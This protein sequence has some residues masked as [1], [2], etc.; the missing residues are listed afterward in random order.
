[1]SLGGHHTALSHRLSGRDNNL[2]L[3]RLIAAMAVLISHAFPIAVGA[4][5][6]E[7]FEVQTGLSLG[8]H[9]VAVFFVLSGL[10]I[11][12]S[13]DR[14]GSR[15]R[16]VTA[17]VMRLFPG[18]AVVLVLTVLAGAAV[19]TLDVTAYL[20]DP[21]TILYVPRNLSLY[22]LQY[23]LP[24]VFED[25][26]MGAAINGSLW[27]LF[28]EVVCYI[29]VF[30]LGVLGVLRRRG[31][32]TVVFA[33]LSAAFLV[34]LEWEPA[35]GLAYRLDLLAH[36]AFPFALGILAYVWRDRLLIDFRI[37]ALLWLLPILAM[38][39]DLLLPAIMVALGYSTIWFGFAV[40]G[41]LLAYNRIGDYSYGLYI[42]AF[43]VQQT[44][45][46]FSS[47]MTPLENI[48]L[49]APITAFLAALSWFLVERRALGLIDPIA[50]RVEALVLRRGKHAGD[51]AG[52]AE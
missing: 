50:S 3:I 27:T 37:A 12:R 31:A 30:I 24:G 43:P 52:Q 51:T 1:M 38:W 32:F 2:N 14:A 26:P 22:F 23:S 47:E 25:N 18:L 7:P 33:L 46:H 19:T 34:S 20:T 5:T 44:L 45:V 40:K 42:Y 10:L 4:G 36:L 28:Y 16:F 6:A 39:S 35:S 8:G 15:L 49:A 17:R 41:P 9:A 29:G 48:L 21:A 13:F 11:A